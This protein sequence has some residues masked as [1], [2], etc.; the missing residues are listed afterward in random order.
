MERQAQFNYIRAAHYVCCEAGRCYSF[1]PMPL[2]KA[3]LL[4]VRKYRINHEPSVICEGLSL[5]GIDAIVAVRERAD[6]PWRVDDLASLLAT[7]S[8]VGHGD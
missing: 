8:G 3:V 2:H 4:A 5:I 6:F 1:G 7:P